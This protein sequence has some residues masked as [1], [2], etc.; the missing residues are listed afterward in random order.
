MRFKEEAMIKLAQIGCGY[1]G[2]NLLRNFSA[3]AECH[4]KLVAD[5]DPKRRAYVEAMYPKTTTSQDWHDAIE[6]PEIDAVVIA[7]PASTHYALIKA[8]LEADKHVFTEKPLAMSLAEADDLLKDSD[9][10]LPTVHPEA[11][12][13]WHLFVVRVFERDEVW[14]QL[15]VSGI[16]AGIHYPVPLHRQPAYAHLGLPAGS[17]PVTERVAACVVSL[18]IYPELSA[19]QVAVVSRTL[20][21]TITIARPA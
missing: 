4:V 21:E 10:V 5:Q 3:H 1:W 16:S 8:A 15:N 14:K 19:E 20:M 18:P 12:S 9:A 6:D 7:T 2:P 11:E 17:L 13:V